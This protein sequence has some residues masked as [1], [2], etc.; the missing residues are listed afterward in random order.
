MLDDFLIRA[1]LAG[2]GTALAAGPIGCFVVWR[3]MAFFGDATAHAGI[4][5]VAMALAFSLPPFVGVTVMALAMAATISALVARGHVMDTTL[6]VVSHGALAAGIVAVSFLPSVRVDLAS[7]LFGDVLSVSRTDLA[8]IW[9][10]AA[11]VAALLWWRW[12]ALLAATLNPDLAQAGGISP[13]REQTVLTIAMALVV[14]VAIKAVGVLLI[15][16]FMIIPAAAARPLTRTPEAMAAGAVLI[17]GS[18]ALAGLGVSLA[19]DTPTGPSMVLV[20]LA[21]FGVTAALGR[22]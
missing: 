8:I 17:G 16:A 4:L 5:G 13:V 6:G 12:S 19:V 10:G 20:A 18:A 14:A 15:A 21:V 7:L 1:G 11:A 9:G 3:R 2:L 22:R